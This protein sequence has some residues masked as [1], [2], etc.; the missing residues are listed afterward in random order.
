MYSRDDNTN[1]K[2]NILFFIQ[3][4]INLIIGY[5]PP[6]SNT[7]NPNDQLDGDMAHVDDGK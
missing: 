1:W 5:E 4:T 3:A 7:P 2:K 6:V